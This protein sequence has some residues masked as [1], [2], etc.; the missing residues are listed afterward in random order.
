MK[1]KNWRQQTQ[2]DF[3]HIFQLLYPD[4][5]DSTIHS[6]APGIFI[7][8]DQLSGHQTEVV[9]QKREVLPYLITVAKQILFTNKIVSKALLPGNVKTF[10]QTTLG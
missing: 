7:K 10:Y 1:N 6:G 4:N 2:V 8:I 5:R 9:P 3:R